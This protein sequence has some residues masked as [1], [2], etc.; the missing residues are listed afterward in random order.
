MNRILSLMIAALMLLGL[1][2][3]GTQ[4]EPEPSASAQESAAPAGEQESTAPDAVYDDSLIAEQLSLEGEYDDGSGNHV[5]YSFHV[6]KLSGDSADAEQINAAINEKFGGFVNDEMVAIGSKTSLVCYS[7]SWQSFWHGSILCLVVKAETD[8][9]FDDYGVYS[10]DFKSGKAV[11][12][13]E[14]AAMAGI[15]EEQ[16]L[17][18]ASAAA[19]AAYDSAAQGFPQDDFY[20]QQR[21]W[22][23]SAE[24]IN[25]DM[26]VYLN[27]ADNI[28][29][30]LPIGSMAGGDWY[31]HVLE[32]EQ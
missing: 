32:L 19:A 5:V 23:L 8:W 15:S 29:L 26:L 18:K 25:S 4:S 14:L 13:E 12:N 21:E 3:C 6:P 20:T 10:F 27:D 17:E 24:N 16:L 11:S 28:T 9:D 2:A 30:I 22:T 7:I 31:Y 1:S